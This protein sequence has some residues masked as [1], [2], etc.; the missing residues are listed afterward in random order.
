MNVLSRLQFDEEL[1]GTEHLQDVFVTIDTAYGPTGSIVDWHG[2]VYVQYSNT[3]LEEMNTFSNT[4]SSNTESPAAGSVSY[5]WYRDANTVPSGTPGGNPNPS[6]GGGGG[7][8][9]GGGMN[10]G[11]MM[12]MFSRSA[13]TM[14]DMMK[15]LHPEGEK[16]AKELFKKV[17]QDEKFK[18]KFDINKETLNKGDPLKKDHY[19]D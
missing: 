13:K 2:N 7:G 12:G 17:N 15:R 19:E 14:E 11:G 3:Q 9:S 16:T 18:K 10:V 1:R 4:I 6:S 8:G 5:L